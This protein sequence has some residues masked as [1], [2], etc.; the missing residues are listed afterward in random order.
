MSDMPISR[1]NYLRSTDVSG[2]HSPGT[3]SLI[4]GI[5][6]SRRRVEGTPVADTIIGNLML[7]QQVIDDESFQNFVTESTLNILDTARGQTMNDALFQKL[8]RHISGMLFESMGAFFYERFLANKSKREGQTRVYIAV[9]PKDTTRFF[10][11]LYGQPIGGEDGIFS[12]GGGQYSPDS[13]TIVEETSGGTTKRNL[14]QLVEFSNSE[15]M[16]AYMR[17]KVEHVKNVC[18]NFAE[19]DPEGNFFGTITDGK[20]EIDL[21]F[22]VPGIP[23]F[24][25]L[26]SDIPTKLTRG[27]HDPNILKIYEDLD[28]YNEDSQVKINIQL[29]IGTLPITRKI[30]QH[31][32]ISR[33]LQSIE[34]QVDPSQTRGNIYNILARALL[35][36]EQSIQPQ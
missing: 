33:F 17:E 3:H 7:L 4:D 11:A 1:E 36:Y 21:V 8:E 20:R 15:T 9:N 26:E 35:S 30:L 10:G 32:V 25:G 13:M 31:E 23:Y 29:V 16:A 24:P 34:H 2:Y 19:V 22:V 5:Q 28:R 12:L 27:S 6:T 14:T 18:A